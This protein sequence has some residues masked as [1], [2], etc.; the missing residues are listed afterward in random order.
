MKKNEVKIFKYGTIAPFYGLIIVIS[1]LPSFYAIYTSFTDKTLFSEEWHF[2]G[3]ANFITAFKDPVFWLALKNNIFYG[4]FCTFFQVTLGLGVALL[5]LKPFKGNSIGRGVIVF[6][7]LVPTIV[8]VMT[9]K[10]LLNDL[11]GIVNHILLRLGVIEQGISWLGPSFAMFT[12]ILVAVWRYLPFAVL[13]FLPGLQAIPGE[14]YDAAKVDGAN[15]IQ[16]FIH[17]TLPQL[18]HVF[19]IVALLR[20]IWMF[21]DFDVIWLLTKGGPVKRTLHIPI[22]SYTEAFRQYDIAQG[23]ATAVAGFIILLVPI[24]LYFRS[25]RE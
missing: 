2:I 4:F 17:V 18:K 5:L 19:L 13:L 14:F 20:G 3:L 8:A 6:P 16:R 22:L 25:T 10:W 11:Y 21:N 15:P 23:S 7:Y 1:A 12:V 24:I 9:F